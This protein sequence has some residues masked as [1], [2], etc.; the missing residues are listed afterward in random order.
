MCVC[1]CV[2]VC[3]CRI[4]DMDS[5]EMNVEACS[6]NSSTTSSGRREGE[7]AGFDDSGV[8]LLQGILTE[9]SSLK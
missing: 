1:V 2:C 5:D 6:G 8:K 7:M 4:I 3:V 9:L